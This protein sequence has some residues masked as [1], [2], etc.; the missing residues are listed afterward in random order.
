MVFIEPDELEVLGERLVTSRQLWFRLEDRSEKLRQMLGKL[1]LT[2]QS[3]PSQ[4]QQ[5]SDLLSK[6]TEEEAW[7]L[8]VLHDFDGVSAGRLE[9]VLGYSDSRHVRFQLG[10]LERFG[11]ATCREGSWTLTRTG[12]NVAVQRA[13]LLKK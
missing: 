9:D 6:L 4:S 3:L 5:I 8:Q 11:L 10:P 13:R 7:T 2:M 12:R 1:E